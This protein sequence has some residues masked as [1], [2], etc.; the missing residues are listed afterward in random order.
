MQRFM[1]QAPHVGSSSSVPTSIKGWAGGVKGT[2]IVL[3][4]SNASYDVI[5]FVICT[6]I[7]RTF[8]CVELL[9]PSTD[10]TI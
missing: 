1:A 9:C 6:L 5:P 3:S 2:T 8:R 7:W 4:N 10:W